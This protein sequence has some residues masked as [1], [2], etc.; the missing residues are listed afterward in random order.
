M[1]RDRKARGAEANHEHPLA[2]G[3][4]GIGAA[5]VERVPARQQRI[6]LEAPR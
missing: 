2:G 3:L 5:Q 1:V 4:F 6:D